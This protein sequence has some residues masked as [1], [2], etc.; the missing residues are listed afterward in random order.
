MKFN[1]ALKLMFHE[2]GTDV[3]TRDIYNHFDILRI[4]DDEEEKK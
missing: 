4:I 2:K 1:Y 3:L